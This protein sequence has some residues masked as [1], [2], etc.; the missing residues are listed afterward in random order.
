MK[1]DSAKILFIQ[2]FLL[3]I[4]LNAHTFCSNSVK[5]HATCAVGV[6]EGHLVNYKFIQFKINTR[7]TSRERFNHIITGDFPGAG[8]IPRSMAIGHLNV[9][10]NEFDSSEQPV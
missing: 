9:N 10:W 6:V 7:P 2:R 8:Q 3:G 4:S 1:I 5:I